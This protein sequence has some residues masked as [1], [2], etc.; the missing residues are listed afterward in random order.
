M[1]TGSVYVYTIVAL[2]VIGDRDL[3]ATDFTLRHTPSPEIKITGLG[4]GWECLESILIKDFVKAVLLHCCGQET[5]NEALSKV[6]DDIVIVLL[7][8]KEVRLFQS[9]YNIEAI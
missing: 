8:Y 4:F 1:S 5:D 9:L 2:A 3:Y 6:N 7:I